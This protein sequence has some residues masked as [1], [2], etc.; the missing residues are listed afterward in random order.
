MRQLFFWTKNY[1]LTLHS[2]L[3]L[4]VPL[5]GGLSAVSFS[6]ALQKDAAP[7]PNAMEANSNERRALSK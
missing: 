1:K 2:T 5:R 6:A 4:G 7:I 3:S